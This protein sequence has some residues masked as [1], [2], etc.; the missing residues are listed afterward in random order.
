MT[1]APHLELV[2]N[3]SAAAAATESAPVI[4]DADLEAMTTAELEA[5]SLE[6]GLQIAGDMEIAE[7]LEDGIEEVEATHNAAL[8][9]ADAE[10]DGIHGQMQQGID[11]HQL[12]AARQKLDE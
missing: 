8:D 12:E 4:T 7:K 6:L 11:D 9:Q 3:P 2:T 5:V 10:L 1:D